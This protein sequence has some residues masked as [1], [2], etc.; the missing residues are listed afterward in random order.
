MSEKNYKAIV[1]GCGR[2]GEN[3]GVHSIGYVHGK[4]YRGHPRIELAGACDLDPAN[5]DRFCQHF[6]VPHQMSDSEELLRRLRPEIVSLCTYVGSRPALIEASI[7]NGARAIWCEKPF[8]LTIQEGRRLVA[9]CEEND[10]KLVINHY[11]RY[12]DLWN[13][14]KQLLQN[15]EIGELEVVYGSFEGWD[16]MEMGTHLLD[17]IRYFMD[18]EP[19]SWVM[20]QVRCTGAKNLYGHKIEEHSICYLAFENGVRGFYDGSR[21]FPGKSLFRLNG[22]Q[23]SIEIFPGGEIILINAK[24]LTRIVADSDWSHPK[25]N[26]RDPFQDLLDDFLG[27]MEGGE[28]PRINGRS[29]LS[30]TEL[31]LACYESSKQRDRID[32]PLAEQDG[33]PLD[34][35]AALRQK[36]FK[37]I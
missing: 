8:S 23:G 27:W 2:G 24:G 9:L 30:S 3:I 12:L 32:L 36:N 25:E 35:I 10:V 1:I 31:Y 18:D 33:F 34:A 7:R 28:P 14:A 6:S 21:P 26:G 19:V 29:G 13:R 17:M 15:G 22:S 37:T 5:L 4:A 16:Q 20:G 11:R